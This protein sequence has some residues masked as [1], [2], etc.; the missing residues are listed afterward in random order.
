M[1]VLLASL[2]SPTRV[3]CRDRASMVMW[4]VTDRPSSHRLASYLPDH[5]SMTHH[6]PPLPRARYCDFVIQF[7][8][9]FSLCRSDVAGLR[10]H[11]DTFADALIAGRIVSPA[12]KRR[13]GEGTAASDDDTLSTAPSGASPARSPRPFQRH[14]SRI[15]QTAHICG[16]S[17]ISD[18][19]T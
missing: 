4:Q 14:P 11:K 5:D 12:T 19:A 10:V 8:T 18:P 6:E 7:R 16:H 17:V 15:R 3:F 13:G 9:F 2:T 1:R